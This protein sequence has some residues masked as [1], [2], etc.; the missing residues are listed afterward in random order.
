[1]SK[2]VWLKYSSHF[3]TILW[4]ADTVFKVKHGVWEPMKLIITYLI[5][6]SAQILALSYELPFW[7]VFSKMD[8]WILDTYGALRTRPQLLWVNAPI[9]VVLFCGHLQ[10]CVAC[11][12]LRPWGIVFNT[13]KRFSI[14]S[15]KYD[16]I[17]LYKE[18]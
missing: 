3:S 11:S 17:S 16:K 6:N 2:H 8:I 13:I 18:W 5:V 4:K 12:V 1:M 15:K 14:K 10:P 9:N 7:H